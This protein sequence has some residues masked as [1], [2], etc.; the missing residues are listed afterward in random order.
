ML[1]NKVGIFL[2]VVLSFS[3]PV[4]GRMIAIENHTRYVIELS[5]QEETKD[6][7]LRAQ[8][9]ECFF[10]NPDCLKEVDYLS[11]L[12]FRIAFKL[13]IMSWYGELKEV[14]LGEKILAREAIL[15]K[16]LRITEADYRRIIFD[17]YLGCGEWKRVGQYTS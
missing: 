3:V 15:G 6:E 14:F 17:E 8:A 1:K 13:S 5:Q 2:G 11:H 12:N 4:M 10:V 9:V 7:Q 16:K